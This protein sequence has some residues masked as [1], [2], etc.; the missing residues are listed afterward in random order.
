MINQ[1]EH[2]ALL[3]HLKLNPSD[4]VKENYETKDTVYVVGAWY[5]WSEKESS[6]ISGKR[7]LRYV[8]YLTN[9]SGGPYL[10]FDI[11]EEANTLFDDPFVFGKTFRPCSS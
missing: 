10:V 5:D 2:L 4:L 8:G 6:F 7:K 9:V 11:I 1:V 3:M